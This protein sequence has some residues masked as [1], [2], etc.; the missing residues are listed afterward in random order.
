[1]IITKELF[2][3]IK[4]GEIFRVVTTR[5]QNFH[6][7]MEETLTFV[8]VKAKGDGIDWAIYAK[9]AGTYVEDIARYGDKVTSEENIRNICPCDDEVFQLYRL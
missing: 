8:C 7:P 2:D 4:P 5:F 6:E 3:K 1:M 9:R